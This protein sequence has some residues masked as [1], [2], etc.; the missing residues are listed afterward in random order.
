MDPIDETPTGPAEYAALNATW[1]ALAAGLLVATREEAPPLA[2]LPLFGLASFALT[3]ALAKE[4]VGVWVRDPLVEEAEEGRPP[5]GSGMRY[6][7]GELVTC[8]RC[9]GTWSS[10]GLVGLRL[11]RPREG[12]I[13]A[14][15][16]ASAAVNDWLQTGFNTMTA[17]ANVEEM[18][19]DTPLDKWPEAASRA[20]ASA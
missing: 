10:L 13:L 15:V 14:T 4:K 2:E 19:A 16:L 17:R 12:R 18:R 5:K 8:T 7:L 9:L 3:K 6:A 1:G 20:A 11:A